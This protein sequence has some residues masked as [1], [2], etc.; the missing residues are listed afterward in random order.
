MLSDLLSN[1]IS[2]GSLNDCKFAKI[3]IYLWQENKRQMS[4]VLNL[5]LSSI[6]MRFFMALTS[7]PIITWKQDEKKNK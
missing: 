5:L 2:L 1:Y 6:L 4:K 7:L 3:S